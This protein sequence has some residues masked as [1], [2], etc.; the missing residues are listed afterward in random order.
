[1]KAAERQAAIGA[2]MAWWSR[3]RQEEGSSRASSAQLRRCSNVFDALLQRETQDLIRA[4]RSAGG[5]LLAGDIDHRLA[6]LA[7][8]LVLVETT[9]QVP[10]AEALG[11]TADGLKPTAN[12]NDRQRL[13]PIR[14][15]SLMRYAHARDWDGFARS[16]RRALA[17]VRNPSFSVSAYVADM[18]FFGDRVLERWTYQYWQT[19]GPEELQLAAATPISSPV[20]EDTP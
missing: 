12:G 18:L 2:A 3:L 1:M 14:F 6:V 17:I 4:V 10:L 13:S 5:D 16:L 20:T 19:S 9:S 11:R 7:I 8:S 15:G